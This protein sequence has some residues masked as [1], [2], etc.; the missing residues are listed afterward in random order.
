MRRAMPTPRYIVSVY[1]VPVVAAGLP[2]DEAKASV[3]CPLT[4]PA[5]SKAAPGKGST[6]EAES[7]RSDATCSTHKDRINPEVCG[8]CDAE[9]E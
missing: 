8:T 3:Q 2:E 4:T 1:H 9:T 6:T 7:D 5:A